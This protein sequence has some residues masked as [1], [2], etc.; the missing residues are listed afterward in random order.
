MA[1]VTA[2]GGPAA[3]APS[4]TPSFVKADGEGRAYVDPS[5]R[6]EATNPEP[7]APQAERP[8]WLQQQFKSPEELA[9]AYDALRAKMDSKAPEAPVAPVVTESK[10]LDMAALRAEVTANGTLSEESRAALKASGIDEA[11][12]TTYV[13]GAKAL[14]TQAHTALAQSVGGEENLNAALSWAKINL[15]DA[16]AS[17]FDRAMQAGDPALAAMAVQGIHSRYLAAEGSDP[18]LISGEGTA[19]AGIEPFTDTHQVTQAM[20]DPRY[21]KSEAY[22][23]QVRQRLSVSSVF[24]R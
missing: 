13:E 12:I 5:L 24:G 4:A 22:R 20:R 11:T 10:G 8:Q 6:A 2:S 1:Q 16:E 23:T 19:P 17:A 18:K 14:A 15:T 3:Q 21:A 7:A 9:K